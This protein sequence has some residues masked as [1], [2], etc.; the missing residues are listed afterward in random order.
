MRRHVFDAIVLSAAIV[1]VQACTG[2]PVAPSARKVVDGAI[3]G[4]PAE[5]GAA[6]VAAQ[7]MIH[8]FCGNV[9]PPI[10]SI[11]RGSHDVGMLVTCRSLSAPF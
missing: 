8:D 1:V 6:R 2:N 10:R 5:V 4:V 9:R 3:T 11:D 7:P